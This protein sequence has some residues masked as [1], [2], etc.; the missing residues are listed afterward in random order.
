MIKFIKKRWYIV[1]ALACV[2]A[3]IVGF[4]INK[5]ASNNVFAS[6]NSLRI[7]ARKYLVKM[8]MRVT[9]IIM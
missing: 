7:S 6:D 8:L 4:A 3:L 1:T 2:I 5:V 9:L